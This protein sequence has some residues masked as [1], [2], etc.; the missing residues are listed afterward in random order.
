MQDVLNSREFR[1][2]LINALTQPL[3]A[4]AL[5]VSIVVAFLIEW[6]WFILI[7]LIGYGLIAYFTFTDQAGNQAVVYKE[8]HPPRRL[9]LGK[10]NVNYRQ[11]IQTALNYQQQIDRAVVTADPAIRN[12][13]K[14]LTTD[15]DE[16]IGATYNIAL[17]AQDVEN[18]MHG[19][20]LNFQSLQADIQQADRQVQR[21]PNDYIR[22]Q[23]E[24]VRDAK[25]QQLANLNDVSVALESWH[26]QLA[27]A[28]ASLGEILSEVLRIRSSRVLQATPATDGL[29]AQVRD[30]VTALRETAK[31]FD[32]IY[33]QQ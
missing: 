25:K 21:A 32:K 17:Q 27:H 11:N 19:S 18:V 26:A 9:D 7:G 30:Q 15:V 23:Y 13:L 6:P 24:A 5:A 4:L 31:A 16:L 29:S 22:S 20:S 28:I 2:I 1:I 14:R 33:A 3:G 8:L 12:T 10:L